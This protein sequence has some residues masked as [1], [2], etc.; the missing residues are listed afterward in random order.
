MATFIAILG[1]LGAIVPALIEVWRAHTDKHTKAISAIRNR[2]RDELRA[3]MERVD[4]VRPVEDPAK[5]LSSRHQT[6]L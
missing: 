4:G 6:S 1:M 5:P 3:G 2:D